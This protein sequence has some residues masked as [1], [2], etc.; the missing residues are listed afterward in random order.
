M[1]LFQVIQR[2]HVETYFKTIFKHFTQSAY[3]YKKFIKYKNCL[4]QITIIVEQK[5]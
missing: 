4:L 5:Q 1:Q 2:I 3:V